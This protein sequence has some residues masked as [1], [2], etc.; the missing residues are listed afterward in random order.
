MNSPFSFLSALATRQPWMVVAVWVL[1]LLAAAPFALRL[2]GALTKFGWDVDGSQSK[3]AHDLIELELPQTYPQN[4]VVVF[5]SDE[6][7]VDDPRFGQVVDSVRRHMIG[8]RIRRPPGR[9]RP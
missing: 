9:G 5:H 4:L 7:D 8:C 3:A 6:T 1:L 2:D